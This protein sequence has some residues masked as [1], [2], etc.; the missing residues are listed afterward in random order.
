MN[1][2]EGMQKLVD[3]V[4]HV[5]RTS[6]GLGLLRSSVPEKTGLSS[7]RYQSQNLVPDKAI[8]MGG[9]IVEAEGLDVGGDRGAVRDSSSGIQ[10]LMV[11]L[12]SSGRK[13][14]RA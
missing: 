4:E 11:R 2:I 1:G 9:G 12:A 3:L 14:D 13:P 7:S 5:G 6:L 8:E 10:R